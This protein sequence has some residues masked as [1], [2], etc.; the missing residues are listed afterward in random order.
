[1]LLLQ[2]A[3]Y[4]GIFNTSRAHLTST[5]KSSITVVESL[6]VSFTYRRWL[7]S[8]P[9][10]P[11]WPTPVR[12]RKVQQKPTLPQDQ[13]NALVEDCGRAVDI[14][15]VALLFLSKGDLPHKSLWTMWLQTA[16][17]QLPTNVKYNQYLNKASVAKGD[18]VEQHGAGGDQGGGDQGG[19][20]VEGKTSTATGREEVVASLL[21]NLKAAE[22]GSISMTAVDAVTTQ[23][24]GDGM[25][26]S[27]G[28]MPQ[29]GQGLDVQPI[30]MQLSKRRRLL[31]ENGDAPPEGTDVTEA[32]G[33][34]GLDRDARGALTAMV[35]RCQVCIV[36][37]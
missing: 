35:D 11:P 10:L 15:R 19:A 8:Q 25:A 1:M 9:N 16:A 2:A 29:Q 17:G 3:V 4:L 24:G 18:D 7:A 14:P 36:C 34:G 5:S 13:L 6:S 31:Q 22:N 30:A 27:N 23:H 37:V 20:G 33:L 28:A 21:M 26:A 12:A 32:Q